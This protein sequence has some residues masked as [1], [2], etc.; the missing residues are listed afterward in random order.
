M[1]YLFTT[2]TEVRLIEDKDLPKEPDVKDFKYPKPVDA[3]STAHKKWRDALE[4]AKKEKSVKVENMIFESESGVLSIRIHDP[5]DETRALGFWNIGQLY[6]LPEGYRVKHKVNRV[7]RNHL[8]VGLGETEIVATI[9]PMEPKEESQ[10]ELW[11]E[12]AEIFQYTIDR[13]QLERL[14]S[15]YTITLKP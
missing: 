8:Y 12:I 13:N 5:L 7:T 4:A 14:K 15:K 11:I 2:D 6:P 1:T 3:Y 10:D 9:L